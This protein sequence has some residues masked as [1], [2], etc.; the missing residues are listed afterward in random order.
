MPKTGTSAP[1]PPALHDY[2][3]PGQTGET[4]TQTVVITGGTHLWSGCFFRNFV[5]I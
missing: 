4:L 3:L 2:K 1:T 5:V